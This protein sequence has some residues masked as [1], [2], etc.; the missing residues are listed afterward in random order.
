M[1]GLF[2]LFFIATVRMRSGS[3]KRLNIN[4]CLAYVNLVKEM[5]RDNK[6]KY[7]DFL[8]AMRD[9]KVERFEH[10]AP[11]SLKSNIFLFL[12]LLYFLSKDMILLYDDLFLYC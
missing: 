12:C 6:E 1:F 3:E 4:D 11:P 5:F 9:L 10:V 2:I 8:E 7:H